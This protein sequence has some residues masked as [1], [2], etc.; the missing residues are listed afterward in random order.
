MVYKI[1]TI[2]SRLKLSEPFALDIAFWDTPPTFL[3]PNLWLGLITEI[4]LWRVFNLVKHYSLAG[5]VK[6]MEKC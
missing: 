1:D 4:R 3:K 6:E 2:I 5:L